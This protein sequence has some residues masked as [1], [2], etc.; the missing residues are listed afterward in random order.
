M[1]GSQRWALFWGSVLVLLALCFLLKALGVIDDV[2]GYFWAGFLILAG[3]GLV[4]SALVPQK[5]APDGDVASVELE[6]AR[7]A[8]VEIEH[9]VGSLEVTGGAPPGVL[10]TVSRGAG[11]GL[12]SRLE[13]ERMKVKVNCAPS[14]IPGIGPEGGVW[15][16]RLTD[17]VPLTLA[18]ESGASQVVLDL[19]DLPVAFCKLEAGATRVALTVPARVA[20]ARIDVEVGAATLDVRIPEGVAARIVFEEGLAAREIDPQRFPPLA[21]GVYQSPD[22]ERAPYRVELRLEAGASSVTIR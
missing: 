22:Y 2:L 18:V 9:G 8:V 7:E 15:R 11:L 5:I 17:Q 14:F 1:S 19:E 10:L 21:G 20:N 12:S 3:V 13:G 16:I 6:G 4:L